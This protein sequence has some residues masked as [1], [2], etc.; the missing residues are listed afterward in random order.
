MHEASRNVPTMASLTFDK[1]KGRTFL[2]CNIGSG[3]AASFWFDNWTGHGALLDLVGANGPR[4]TGITRLASVSD[5]V[6][7]G[8]WTLPRG[9]HPIARLLRTLLPSSLNLARMV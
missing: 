8:V 2:L 5:A 1:E 3:Q 4:V 7:D 6:R 9:R